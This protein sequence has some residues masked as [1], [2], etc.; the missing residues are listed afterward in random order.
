MHARYF[1]FADKAEAES[2]LL[3]LAEDYDGAPLPRI[4]RLMGIDFEQVGGIR[5]PAKLDDRDRVVEAAV[6]HPGFH[7][8]MIVPDGITL[9]EVLE[10]YEI[11]PSTPV[12]RF[13]V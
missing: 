10:A 5:K 7:V 8:N 11:F 3:P 9:P 1:R 6:V 13:G 4:G 2:V 12:R